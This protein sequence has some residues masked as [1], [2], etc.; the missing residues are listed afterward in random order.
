MTVDD[1]NRERGRGGLTRAELLRRSAALAGVVAGGG[2][3]AACSAGGGGGTA[4][5]I[6]ARRPRPLASSWQ[7]SNWPKSSSTAASSIR[8]ALSCRAAARWKDRMLTSFEK[9]RDRLDVMMTG[10][11]ARI[12]DANGGPVQLTTR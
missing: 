1:L 5:A 4:A 8:C 3:L 9:E 10:R 12:S 6:V 11:G 7:I 2:V